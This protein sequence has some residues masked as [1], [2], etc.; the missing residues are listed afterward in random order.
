M[1]LA[2]KRLTEDDILMRKLQENSNQAV[3]KYS[4]EN[5]SDAFISLFSP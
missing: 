5:A 1:F 2:V 4:M 3:R